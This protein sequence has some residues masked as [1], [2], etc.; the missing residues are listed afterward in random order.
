VSIG[1]SENTASGTLG[2][3]KGKREEDTA[4]S[5]VNRTTR[6]LIESFVNHN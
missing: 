3:T 4:S 2:E 5:L 6:L 1:P